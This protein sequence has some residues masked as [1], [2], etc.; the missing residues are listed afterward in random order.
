[1]ITFK[2]DEAVKINLYNCL[3]DIALKWYTFILIEK[4]KFYVKHE[5]NIDYWIKIL[6][7]R[8]KK[9]LFIALIIVIKKRYIM[10]DARRW[11]EFNEYA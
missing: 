1:M 11:R 2:D 3:R 9:S 6:F 10:N 7:K 8:W 4:Q 5:E